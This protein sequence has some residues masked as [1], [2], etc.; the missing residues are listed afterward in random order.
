[1]DRMRLFLIVFLLCIASCSNNS[2]LKDNDEKAKEALIGVWRGFSSGDNDLGSGKGWDEY[3][4]ISRYENGIFKINYLL[5]NN[6]KKEYEISSDKGKWNFE[7]G[8]YY[9]IH[10]GENKIIYKVHSLKNDWFEYNQIERMN[11]EATIQE[12]K[13]VDTYQ[14]QEPPLN[15]NQ[16]VRQGS[17]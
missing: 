3:W 8:K 15:Y 13:T 6:T 2:E 17:G 10:N 4:K 14:L 9:E 11:S 5:I 12:V 7:N 16:L 1:M